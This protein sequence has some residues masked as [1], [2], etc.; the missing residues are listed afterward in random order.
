MTLDV[1]PPHPPDLTT[2]APDAEE[3]DRPE[4]GRREEIETILHDGAWARAFGEWSEHTDLTEGD[5][6]IVTDLELTGEFDVWW[7][8]ADEQVRYEA[9]EIGDWAD[10]GVHPD[11]TSHAQVS[12]IDHALD[13]L[14]QTVVDLLQQ[15]YVDW[16]TLEPSDEPE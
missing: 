9:P 8:A 5:W 15:E 1:D 3:G 10:G 13:D 14:G 7:D 11:L 12:A 6:A 2:T 16:D 4:A